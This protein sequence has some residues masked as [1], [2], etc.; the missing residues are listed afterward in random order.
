ML[1]FPE[2]ELLTVNC[3]LNLLFFL[4]KKKNLYG[5]NRHFPMLCLYFKKKKTEVNNGIVKNPSACLHTISDFCLIIN[6]IT[7]ERLT[8]Y[9][10]LA[11]KKTNQRTYRLEWIHC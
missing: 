5:H 9:A 11:F 8:V 2:I 6:L 4:F 10:L 1:F 3:A 7:V